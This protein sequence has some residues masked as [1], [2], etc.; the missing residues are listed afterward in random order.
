VSLSDFERAELAR[1]YAEDDRLRAEHAEWMARREAQRQALVRKSDEQ[2]A[3]TPRTTEDATL[4]VSEPE[5]EG[6]NALQIDALAHLVNEVRAELQHEWEQHVERVEQRLLA[7]IVRMVLP[8]EVAEREI[9]G[10]KDRIAIL[11]GRI[12]RQLQ[13]GSRKRVA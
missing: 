1:I 3:L 4:P 2:D 11:E 7:S 8:G 6:F 12:E 5:P 9:F 13:N 10:L